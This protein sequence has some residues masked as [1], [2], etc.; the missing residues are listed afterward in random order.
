MWNK[1]PAFLKNKYLLAFLAFGIWIIFF[2]RNN[3]IH[4]NKLKQTLKEHQQEKEYYL[5]EIE[6]DSLA[7][8]NLL[9]DT[10]N[11]IRFGREKYLMKKDSE[12]IFL[13]IP[14]ED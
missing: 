1:I 8:H 13:V 2:D 14:K 6:N 11:L 3:I 9:S 10:E 4:R 5:Q 7:L 12:V